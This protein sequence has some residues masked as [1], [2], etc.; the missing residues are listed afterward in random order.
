MTTRRMLLG[1]VLSL[2]PLRFTI[3]QL[4]ERDPPYHIQCSDVLELRLRFTPEF[5]QQL[6]VQ[7]DGRVTVAGV[8]DTVVVGLTME[9]VRERLTSLLQK[10]LKDPEIEVLLKDF[11]K[12]FVLVGG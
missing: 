3:A 10:R 1:C 7:P 6:T 8:G 11:Q 12:P 4:L 5:N 9:Q 2:V